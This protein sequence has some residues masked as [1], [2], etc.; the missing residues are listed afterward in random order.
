MKLTTKRSTI[1]QRRRRTMKRNM[2]SKKRPA[3]ARGGGGTVV[4]YLSELAVRSQDELNSFF[5]P[6][7]FFDANVPGLS[8]SHGPW[9]PRSVARLSAAAHAF[10]RAVGSVR[11]SA[12]F[13]MAFSCG[14][15]A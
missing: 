12:L 1:T 9:T 15:F 7:P 4:S 13:I 3:A 6:F 2:G 11:A 10:A 8:Q 5:T 14:S